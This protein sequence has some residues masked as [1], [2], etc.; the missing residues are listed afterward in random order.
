MHIFLSYSINHFV[1]ELMSSLLGS[2]AVIYSAPVFAAQ[3]PMY[4]L[5]ILISTNLER[6][7]GS[8]YKE[9]LSIRNWT[10]RKTNRGRLRQKF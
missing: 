5:R 7:F 4:L 9:L 6:D 1:A 10:N 2:R 8:L 3:F